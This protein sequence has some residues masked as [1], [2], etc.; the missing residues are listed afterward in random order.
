MM[1]AGQHAVQS[2]HAWRVSFL[3][4]RHVF[5][6]MSAYTGLLVSCEARLKNILQSVST[7]S[8]SV[9]PPTDA[10]GESRYVKLVETGYGILN[11]MSNRLSGR[12][13]WVAGLQGR[14]RGEEGWDSEDSDAAQGAGAHRRSSDDKCAPPLFSPPLFPPFYPLISRGHYPP[15]K[16]VGLLAPLLCPGPMPLLPR[17][18]DWPWGFQTAGRCPDVAQFHRLA[19][20]RRAL[21]MVGRAERALQRARQA[22]G[23]Q[24]ERLMQAPP[25]S[26]RGRR[27]VVSNASPDGREPP[28]PAPGSSSDRTRPLPRPPPLPPL[29]PNPCSTRRSAPRFRKRCTCAQIRAVLCLKAEALC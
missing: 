12:G 15:A 18:S 24:R 5:P 8:V 9:N 10:L 28:S 6:A 17:K 21:D 26:L 1:E 20:A 23:D 19:C 4:E 13:L 25:P 3:S 22:A 11:R 2:V 16:Y 7:W 27:P 14:R 29:N